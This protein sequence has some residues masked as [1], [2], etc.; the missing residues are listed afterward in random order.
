[1]V[2]TWGSALDRASRRVRRRFFSVD[3]LHGEMRHFLHALSRHEGFWHSLCAP[4]MISV[5][6][7]AH[8]WVTK[9]GVA[10]CWQSRSWY[11][12]FA[13]PTIIFF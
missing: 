13:H 8:Q 3:S 11:Q 1:M 12:S 2:H 7:D 5:T 9:P 6:H 4:V 10:F